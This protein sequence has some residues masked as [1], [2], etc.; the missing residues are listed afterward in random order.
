MGGANGGYVCVGS[1]YAADLPGGAT[2]TF[3]WVG[4]FKR[5]D[6][7][8]KLIGSH[9]IPPDTTDCKSANCALLTLRRVV[10]VAADRVLVTGH[11][12]RYLSG[13]TYDTD[14]VIGLSPSGQ[15]LWQQEVYLDHGIVRASATLP[16]GETLLGVWSPLGHDQV[17]SLGA[18][19]A[20]IAEIALAAGGVEYVP[21]AL[22]AL[23][24][25]SLFAAG[26]HGSPSAWLLARTNRWLH[27]SCADAGPCAQMPAN[28]CADG[29]PCTEDRCDSWHGGCFHLPTR[30]GSHCAPGKTCQSG[31]CL[32][33]P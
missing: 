29:S 5:F 22:V 13:S 2:A 3:Q 30:K 10:A 25:G 6:A 16:G 15:T 1:A 32:A 33:K 4:V 14:V 7:T 8:G 23:S 24:D 12:L 19:G 18:D 26:L 27:L 9:E 17:L 31:Q 21:S 11:W 20:Q 28:A